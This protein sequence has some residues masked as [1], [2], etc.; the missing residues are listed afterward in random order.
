MALSSSHRI[1]TWNLT[2]DRAVTDNVFSHLD[3]LRTLLVCNN[4][5]VTMVATLTTT[6]QHSVQ[7]ESP[8]KPEIDQPVMRISITQLMILLALLTTTA[9]TRERR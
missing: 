8:S 3:S 2:A 9:C 7:W 5:S 6:Y 1:E 4:E